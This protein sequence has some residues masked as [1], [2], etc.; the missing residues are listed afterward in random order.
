MSLISRRLFSTL[1]TK[2]LGSN[3]TESVEES[4]SVSIKSNIK[5]EEEFYPLTGTY[6]GVKGWLWNKTFPQDLRNIE[7]RINEHVGGYQYN[8]EEGTKA[9]HW[10][11]GVL[12]GCEIKTIEAYKDITSRYKWVPKLETGVYSIYHFNKK[13]FSNYS[14]SKVAKT[15]QVL[16]EELAMLNSVEICIFKRDSSFNNIPAYR[17]YYDDTPEASGRSFSF[18]SDVSPTEDFAERT[19]VLQE[20][21]EIQIGDQQADTVEAIKSNWELI[22]RSTNRS[23][24]YTEYFP[25]DDIKL[26]MIKDSSTFIELK[27]ID[28]FN[29]E[30]EIDYN[31]VVDKHSGKISFNTFQTKQVFIKE[32]LGFALELF[33]STDDLPETG[34]I[35][36]NLEY[37]EKTKYKLILNTQDR[38]PTLNRGSE[39][40]VSKKS[41]VLDSGLDLYISYTAYPRIDYE[42][43]ESLFW[44]NNI[45]VKPYQ[46]IDSGGILEISPQEKHL[47]KIKLEA[48]KNLI[49]MNVYDKLFIQGDYSIIK[50]TALNGN[51][52]P[53][54]GINIKFEA[55]Y[56]RFEGDS[57]SSTK[58]TNLLG[59]AKTTYSVP[60]S[61]YDRFEYVEIE[62]I[63]NSSR[64][65]LEE[66]SLS[67]SLDD[68]YLFQVL[69]TDPYYGDLGRK[70]SIESWD[71]GEDLD[72]STRLI[73][74]KLSEIIEDEEEYETYQVLERNDEVTNSFDICQP[75]VG[76][77]GYAY[78]YQDSLVSR[79]LLIHKINKDEI[80]LLDKKRY[81]DIFNPNE[82]VIFKRNEIEF[83]GNGVERVAYSYNEDQDLFVRIKPSRIA[84]NYVWYDNILIP[85]G[86]ITDKSNLIAGYK[87]YYG[88]LVTIKATGTDPAT[89][90]T[91]RSNDIRMS[92]DLPNFLKGK[93]NGFKFFSED[94]DDSS[95][96]GFANFITINPLIT[97]QINLYL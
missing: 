31:F 19:L 32:D 2:G 7:T 52:K 38:E 27:E 90:R 39:V 91:I 94:N 79:R 9:K 36:N 72:D 73:K 8:L 59:E 96:L 29:E 6:A 15:T 71:I 76:N 60:Y 70:V 81:E 10:Y 1:I 83:N 74:I 85:Q 24:G 82:I 14:T 54:E 16:L 77:Y 3:E 37:K 42:I 20:L 67:A 55:E 49:G 46:K 66:S 22:G 89:G 95:G 87:L 97:N 5:T 47:A 18:L 43:K 58:V 13:L 68:F 65:R 92:L 26:V 78:L 4:V 75:L 69:K 61:D 12:S 62:H 40:S 93:E 80:I 88:K 63:G 48:D 41:L 21:G 51:D 25:I 44:D 35:N 53:V 28:S 86:S 33:E 30:P 56:G 45:N 11:G 23:I 50:A 57:L 84:N 17:W 64:V 34:I